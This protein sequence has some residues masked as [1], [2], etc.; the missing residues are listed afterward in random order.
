MRSIWTGH[1]TFG[2]ISIPVKLYTAVSSH[3]V[4]FSML[5]KS[6]GAHIR[7]KRVDEKSGREVAWDD[8]VKGYEVEDG[9]YVTFTHDELEALDVESMREIDIDTFVELADIDPIYY[10]STYYIA[11]QE[12]GEKAYHLLVKA[13]REGEKVGIAKFAMRQKEH[14][15]A[16]R[17]SG[18]MLVLETMYWPAE[19][20]SPDDLEGLDK[21][22]SVREREVDM[23]M[24]LVE[25]LTGPFEPE[26][27][28]NTFE[29]HVKAA[30][31][32]KLAGHE[33][34]VAEDDVDRE[35]VSD[36]MAALEQS[37]KAARAGHKPKL[38]TKAAA[39][40]RDDGDAKSTSSKGT[41]EPAKRPHGKRWLLDHTKDELL[42][43]AQDEDVPG[44][45][46]MSKE[47]LV[48]ALAK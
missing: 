10:D 43:I 28:R 17:V 48:E 2:L 41:K 35:P 18:D 19:I 6:S 23:A 45:S 12:G 15:A 38:P 29:A 4:E 34:T 14:L 5:H 20:R 32:E 26:R 33:I 30:A 25:Q 16:L 39:A 1:I 21:R 40:K 3:R 22:P 8:I 13:L 27:Y 37:L 11:P 9:Q 46:K 36:L 31:K 42:E 24:D 7:N 44:R 47:D